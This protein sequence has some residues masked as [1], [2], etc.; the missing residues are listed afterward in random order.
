MFHFHDEIVQLHDAMY[1]FH[2]EMCTIHVMMMH[3]HDGMLIFHDGDI[4]IHDANNMRCACF[5][6]TMQ[7]IAQVWMD[8]AGKVTCDNKICRKH[9]AKDAKDSLYCRD[10]D[11]VHKTGTG[12]RQV[13]S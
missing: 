5:V 13:P 7:D 4:H 10:P 12:T 2:D 6:Q 8:T 3:S 9:G 1:I 11:Y